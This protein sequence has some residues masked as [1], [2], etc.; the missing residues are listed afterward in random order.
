[1]L[2]AKNHIV[3]IFLFSTFFI[4][5]S[6]ENEKVKPLPISI[7]TSTSE[8]ID[9][10][11]VYHINEKLN[12]TSYQFLLLDMHKIEEGYFS[13]P[14]GKIHNVPTEYIYDSYNKMY[15]NSQ[16]QKSFFKVADLYKVRSKN[17]L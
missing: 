5:F 6:Q 4:G 10:N 11:S 1:M 16:L 15:Q 14:M 2:F 12:L 7:Y 13:I 8:T 3:L 17:Q 9:F